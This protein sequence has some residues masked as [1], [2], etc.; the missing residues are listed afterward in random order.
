MGDEPVTRPL[1]DTAIITQTS[2]PQVGFE[3]TIPVFERAK[4]FHALDCDQ[5]IEYYTWEKILAPVYD[6]VVWDPIC[7]TSVFWIVVNL[8]CFQF[9][10]WGFTVLYNVGFL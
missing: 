9:H 3:L 5:L 4:T 8:F 6:P 2:M 10:I 7:Y 1:P